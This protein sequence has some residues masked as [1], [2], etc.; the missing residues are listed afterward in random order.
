MKAI[1]IDDEKLARMGLRHLLKLIPDVQIIAEAT[2]GDE[3][4]EAIVEHTPDLIFLD[5]NMPEM[6]GF[7]MLAQLEHKPYI[8]FT[9]AHSEFALEAIQNDAI[10]YLLKPVD[11][12]D[13]L[14]AVDKV[15][16]ITAAP[17]YDMASL[18]KMIQPQQQYREKFLMKTG[19][20]YFPVN[21]DEVAYF[22]AEDKNVFTVLHDGRK[23]IWDESLDKLEPQLD[24]KKMYRANRQF[25]ISH[26]S[27]EVV[28]AWFKGKLKLMLKPTLA[29]EV[30]VSAEKAQLFKS[31]MGS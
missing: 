13:L 10:D 3:G 31:W 18:M 26:R 11:A 14:N 27:V 6:N 23:F 15:R 8:I 12:A 29:E 21:L 28:H 1:I 9:T 17:Q 24:P 5:I 2:N 16:K 4:I 25:I 20:K 7:E 19:Q 22:F 30:I